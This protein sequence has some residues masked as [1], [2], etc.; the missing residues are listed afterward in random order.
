VFFSFVIDELIQT[1]R[2]YV[3]DLAQIVEVCRVVIIEFISNQSMQFVVIL[4]HSF[5][6]CE[7]H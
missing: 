5:Y 6:H 1:E 3:E 7:G 2:T 4:L